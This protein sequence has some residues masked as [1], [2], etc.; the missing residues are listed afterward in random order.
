MMNGKTHSGFRI[1]TAVISFAVLAGVLVMAGFGVDRSDRVVHVFSAYV[2]DDSTSIDT[3]LFFA[4]PSIVM[5]RT[6]P[7]AMFGL[8]IDNSEPECR[9]RKC[10]GYTIELRRKGVRV[11]EV[12][13]NAWETR[14]DL[15]DVDGSQIGVFSL[16]LE[17]HMVN[18]PEYT[19][20]V[21]KKNGEEITVVEQDYTPL[22]AISIIGLP[23][24]QYRD[25][26]RPEYAADGPIKF[27]LSA[28]NNSSFD[29]EYQVFWKYASDS[30]ERLSYEKFPRSAA[31]IIP[32]SGPLRTKIE[33]DLTGLIPRTNWAQVGVAVYAGPHTQFVETVPFIVR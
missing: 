27:T 25:S 33:I 3:S 8:E 12:P 16:Y 11:G 10:W 14:N 6:Y 26:I 24:E 17:G 2:G 13:L 5:V 20:Y 18:P 23:E 31:G 9:S 30:E 32:P 22:P 29:W 15:Y 21:L 19:S 7:S 1:V 28:Q 4:F